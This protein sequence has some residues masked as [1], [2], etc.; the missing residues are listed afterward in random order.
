MAAGIQ[1]MA[2]HSCVY[3]KHLRLGGLFHYQKEDKV[4]REIWG[5]IWVELDGGMWV[6]YDQNT[7]LKCIEFSKNKFKISH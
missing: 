5:R 6:G 2:S 4:G 3:G 1:G 7:L